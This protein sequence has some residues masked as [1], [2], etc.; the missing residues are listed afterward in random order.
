MVAGEFGICIGT[1]L[2]TCIMQYV[3]SF[4]HETSNY[5]VTLK[6]SDEETHVHTTVVVGQ[7]IVHIIQVNALVKSTDRF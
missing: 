6:T 3:P 1:F 5:D 7:S 4:Y 2:C